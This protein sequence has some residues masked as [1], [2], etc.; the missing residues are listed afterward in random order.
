MS[1]SPPSSSPKLPFRLYGF[2]AAHTTT[3]AP[4][5][6]DPV[7]LLNLTPNRYLCTPTSCAAWRSFR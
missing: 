1:N 3:L 6:H 5:T 7:V 2:K 4:D